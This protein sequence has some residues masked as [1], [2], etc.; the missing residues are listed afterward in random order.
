MPADEFRR[1]AQSH[2]R[3]PAPQS[4]TSAVASGQAASV[5][6][7]VDVIIRR[8]AALGIPG[9]RVT[10]ALGLRLPVEVGW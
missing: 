3:A 10:T 1:D 9:W 6:D 5:G 2:E 4:A 7:D 8:A